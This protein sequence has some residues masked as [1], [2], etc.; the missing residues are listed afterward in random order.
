MSVLSNAVSQSMLTI[1]RVRNGEFAVSRAVIITISIMGLII[2]GMAMSMLWDGYRERTLAKRFDE[3]DSRTTLVIEAGED[4]AEARG[5]TYLALKAP[6]RPSKKQLTTI[7]S[8]RAS[9]DRYMAQALK[10]FDPRGAGETKALDVYREL[11]AAEDEI[12]KVADRALRRPVA[13]RDPALADRYLAAATARIV[14][15]QELR[16]AMAA[17]LGEADGSTAY[18]LQLKEQ[19]WVMSEYAGRERALVAGAIAAREP[20]SPQARATIIENRGR[21]LEAWD[22]ARATVE[23]AFPDPRLADAMHEARQSFFVDYDQLRGQVY[24]ASDAGLRYPVGAYQWFD[25]STDA[26][27]SLIAITSVAESV[28]ADIAATRARAANFAIAFQTFMSALAVFACIGLVWV[29]RREIANPL[30]MLDRATRRI[31]KGK[32]DVELPTGARAL[33]VRQL[34]ITLARFKESADAR[35]RLTREAAE[36]EKA[37]AEERRIRLESE[38]RAVEEREARAEALS[39]TA[40]TFSRQMHEAVSALAAA[41]DE[42]NATADLMVTNLSE[43]TGALGAVSRETSEASANVNAAAA[44]AEQIRQAIADIAARVEEQRGASGA[45]ADRSSM[46]AGQ[47]RNLSGATQAVGQMVEMID[48]VAKKT[49]LLALN[50]TIEAARAGEAGR[51]FAVVAGEVKTLS[52]QTGEATARAGETVGQMVHAIEHSVTGFAEVDEAIQRVSQAATAIAASIRQQSMATHELSGG[53]ESAAGIAGRVAERAAKVEQTAAA[54]MAAASEVK[55][56]SGEL[57]RLAEAVRVDVEG[58]IAGL[59]AA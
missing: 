38:A 49:S 45:A 29:V 9:G 16:R 40:E 46:T 21:V 34:A 32:Y 20:I 36:A 52:E 30:D 31:L 51:G 1:R 13:E 23:H 41:A 48:D 35:E 58:F 26:I 33:E 8:A 55:G 50:A 19:A 27:G 54:A 10:G 3:A 2:F 42:L 56:A 17:N 18:L 12:G 37:Q 25:R 53:V 14:A 4:W 57:S 39:K 43:T 24:G 44:A 5:L 15:A 59:K 7:L 6:A 11:E 22:A 47:V 28:A